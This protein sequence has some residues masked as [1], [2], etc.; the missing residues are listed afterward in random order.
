[1]SPDLST[2]LRERL[3]RLF[4]ALKSEMSAA[5]L[6]GPRSQSIRGGQGCS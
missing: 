5:L 3:E 1:M 6:R 2:V 4:E